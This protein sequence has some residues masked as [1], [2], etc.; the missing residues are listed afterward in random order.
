MPQLQNLVLTDRA[1]TPVNHTFKPQKIEGGV[2][3]V[4]ESTGIPIGDNTVSLSTN[5]TASGRRKIVIKTKFPSV[6]NSTVDGITKPVI[7]RTN[8]ADIT[9][10]F[11]ET[12]T[13]AERNDIVGMVSSLLIPTKVLINDTVIKLEGVY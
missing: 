2:A 11:D 4:A 10:N 13:E 8:Y 1:A 6:Q 3:V 7:V 12:S 9:F 5:R